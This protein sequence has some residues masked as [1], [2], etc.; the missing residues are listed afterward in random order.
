MG[1]R[2][3]YEYNGEQMTLSQVERITGKDAETLRRRIRLGGMTLEEAA[4]DVLACR[5]R[6]RA[7]KRFRMSVHDLDPSEVDPA[8]FAW[9]ICS[10][11]YSGTPEES[12][13]SEVEPDRVYTFRSRHYRCRV[14]VDG[15][16]A[17]L[18]VF[19][20]KSGKLSLVRKYRQS[21]DGVVKMIMG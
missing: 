6:K 9:K 7:A 11:I 13:F 10:D 8:E 20:A 21:E 15:N 2:E 16:H 1:K 3:L 19:W 4:E 12:E 17:E 5:A 18:Q 14:E